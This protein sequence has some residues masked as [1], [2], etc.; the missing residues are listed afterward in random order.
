[1]KTNLIKHLIAGVLFFGLHLQ[2][3]AATYNITNTSGEIDVE[4]YNYINNIQDVYIFNTNTFSTISFYLIINSEEDYDYV[5]IWDVDNSGNETLLYE[6]SGEY[7]GIVTTT[8][9]SGRAKVYIRTDHSY[10]YYDGDYDLTGFYIGYSAVGNYT[11]TQSSINEN[12]LSIVGKLGVGIRTPQEKLHVDGAIRGNVGNTGA[13]RVKTTQGYIDIGPSTPNYANFR[14]NQSRFLFDRSLFI[15]NGTLSAYN[16]SNLSLQT[17]GTARM[18]ILSANGNVG[19]GYAIPMEKLHINGSIRGNGSKGALRVKT[20]QG[21]IDIGPSITNYANFNTNQSRFLF[22]RPL[23][24]GNGELSAYDTSNLSLQTN[25]TTRMTILS[26]SGNVG[27]GIPT[28]QEKLHIN[29]PI[30]GSASS[31]GAVRVQTTGGYID[32]GPQNTYDAHFSTD[33]GSFVFNQTIYSGTGVFGTLNDKN[34][35]FKTNSNSTR[36]TI[37]Q[38]NGN[39]GIGTTSPDYKLDVAGVIRCSEVLVQGIDQI[40]DFVFHPDYSLPSLQQVDKFISSNGHL[41]GIPSEAEVKEKGLGLVEM[42]I[43]LLQ[44]VEELTLYV[45]EQEKRALEQEKR[46]LEQERRIKEL[47]AELMNK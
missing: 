16:T 38:S 30:R 27:I 19:I 31:T 20:M 3:S 45:I 18:T 2:L 23:F 5:E 10:C 15:E 4:Y 40:A 7:S 33:K 29:G 12:N 44:K 46:V 35:V 1:M 28:P 17:N 22:D 14:T 43:K 9:P 6:F 13:L 21:Y 41:P 47:E 39:V 25:G 37:L 32:I 24:I 26:A 36:M 8:S 34:L 11:S 42:Q